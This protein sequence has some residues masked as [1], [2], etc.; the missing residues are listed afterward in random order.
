MEIEGGAKLHGATVE[1]FGD[2]RIAMA[3]AILATFAD[4]TS[5]ICDTDCVATSY[6]GFYETLR[7][8][9]K[10]EPSGIPV[11]SSLRAD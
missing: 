4:G 11:I 7:K 9:A 10:S 8:L 2:H 1:S 3:F 6:P 5:H